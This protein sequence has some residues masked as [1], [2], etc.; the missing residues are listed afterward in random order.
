MRAAIC[1]T[2]GNWRFL[3]L[4]DQRAV[5]LSLISFVLKPRLPKDADT[6]FAWNGLTCC[7][8]TKLTRKKHKLQRKFFEK[9]SD[10]SLF[11]LFHMMCAYDRAFSMLICK[12]VQVSVV[13]IKI[14]NHQCEI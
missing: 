12:I 3:D 2:F 10:E 1:N 13:I 9:I 6:R 14:S 5:S 11:F 4:A 7:T 8:K